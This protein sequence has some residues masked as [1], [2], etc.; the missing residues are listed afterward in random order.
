VTVYLVGAGPG[1]PGLL[2]MR[3]AEVLAR[4]DVVVY[5]RLSVGTLLDLAPEG[6]ERISV[7]K[8]PGRPSPPQ[9]EID[10][11]LVERGRSGAEVVRLKGGDPFVFARGGEEAAALLA[12]GVPFEVVPGVTSAVAVPAYGGVPLT[13]RGL[14]TSFTVVTGREG[15]HRGSPPVDW[16]T[17]ARLKGTLVILMGVAPRAEIARR[18]LAGGLASDTPVA[19]VTWGTRPEQ[20]TVRTTLAGLGEAEVASPAVI[21]VG[22]VAALDLRWFEDRPLFGRRVVVTR[23]REQAS[24]LSERLRQLGA[25]TVEV[26]VIDVGEPSDGGAALEDATLR[27]GDYDWAVFTSANTVARFFA[28]LGRTGGDARRLAGVRVA[29]IGPGTGAALEA[30]GIRPDLVPERFVAESLVEAFPDGPGR[31]LL[32]RAAVAR[33][34]L[35]DGLTAKGWAVDVVEAYRTGLGRPSPAAVELA[36]TADAVTFT[37]SSTV[38]N[39]LSVMGE[40]PLPGTVVCIGPITARTAEEAG[41]PVHAVAADHNLDGLVDALVALLGQRSRRPT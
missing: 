15:E 41:L 38:T 7:G 11:L 25:E 31:V 32:P 13:H 37:S 24:N 20:R 3:G 10:A 35:P 16:D 14:S 21:V 8:A 28:A 5:D 23:S 30:R 33:D 6:A 2:T 19:A 9:E 29:A 1:D 40:A 17:L 18:L 22:A 39:Y 36:R 4:A 12:A 26:P 34:A 27:V